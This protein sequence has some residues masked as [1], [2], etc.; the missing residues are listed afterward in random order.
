MI[1][2]C[3]DEPFFHSHCIPRL[4][5]DES[6]PA[7]AGNYASRPFTTKP[8]S[9]LSRMLLDEDNQKGNCRTKAINAGHQTP[10]T[11]RVNLLSIFMSSCTYSAAPDY[12]PTYL[13][14]VP[15]QRAKVPPTRS[16]GG[17]RQA[18]DHHSATYSRLG[19]RS[20]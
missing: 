16:L 12:Q 2:S 17:E 20:S 7:S 19:R 15:Y 18:G 10:V 6:A 8:Q 13:P 4:V 1:T 11:K 9:N 5:Q 3:L 14:K